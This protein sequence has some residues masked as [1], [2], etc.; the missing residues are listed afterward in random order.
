MANNPWYRLWQ[1]INGHSGP[2]TVTVDTPDVNVVN[3]GTND[4]TVTLNHT[5]VRNWDALRGQ[6][7][8]TTFG[9]T[10][11]AY[12][13]P[14]GVEA[15]LQFQFLADPVWTYD[16][17]SDPAWEAA[18]KRADLL[19]RQFLSKEQR[20][21]YKK[22]TWFTVETTTH[23]YRFD[24]YGGVYQTEPTPKNMCIQAV[25]HRIPVADQ[26]LAKLML[27]HADEDLFRLVANSPLTIEA[28]EGARQ[29]VEAAGP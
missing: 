25:D 13:I 18:Q 27:L 15:E 11:H 14:A 20:A 26:L 8:I 9:D 4:V 17:P 21:H 22:W 29:L 10:D 5:A 2:T 23:E 3:L 16:V 7:E 12:V 24:A 6:V 1:R 28:A 19:L